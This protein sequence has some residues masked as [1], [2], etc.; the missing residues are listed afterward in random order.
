M[1]F[2]RIMVAVGAAALVAI[3]GA[4]AHAGP[5]A[6]AS[7]AAH[8]PASAVP[9]APSEQDAAFLE[10]ANDINL[11]GIAHGRIAF[12]KTT[13]PEVKKIAARLMVDHIR[14]NGELAEAARNLKFRLDSVPSAEQRAVAD[15]YRAAPAGAFDALYLSTQLELHQEAKRIADA[16]VAGGSDA[17]VKRVAAESGPVLVEHQKILRDA[18]S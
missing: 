5:V 3:P 13:N 8:G 12:T 15:R 16:Q 6:T 11:A 1:L 4:A 2:R 17:G 18:T 14:L 9:A 7:P 10:A